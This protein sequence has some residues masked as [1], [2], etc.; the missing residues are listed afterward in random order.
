[1][2]EV[3]MNFDLGSTAQQIV[4]FYAIGFGAVAQLLIGQRG[5][6]W[7]WL[8][9]ALGWLAGALFASEVLFSSATIDEIQPMIEGLAYDEALLGG[10]VTGLLAVA[11]AV[12]WH[13]GHVV[14]VMRHA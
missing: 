2:E 1:V 4:I 9:G 5:P 14:P 11:A 13:R 8:A 6:N 7:I 10:L 3:D 12:L